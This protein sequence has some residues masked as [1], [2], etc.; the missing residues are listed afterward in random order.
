MNTDIII[1]GWV[2]TDL[3][4]SFPITHVLDGTSSADIDFGAGSDEHVTCWD[5]KGDRRGTGIVS[6][7]PCR[8]WYV[9]S[10]A[11]EGYREKAMDAQQEL[12][13]SVVISWRTW[14]VSYGSWKVAAE[15][16]N[17][18]RLSLAGWLGAG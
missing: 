3:A 5:D 18:T 1:A 17:C 4:L 2:C 6:W 13:P 14:D 11:T 7:K 16:L 9:V 12:G 15:R 8:D 10:G